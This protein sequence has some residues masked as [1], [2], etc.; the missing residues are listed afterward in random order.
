MSRVRHQNIEINKGTN[1]NNTSQIYFHAMCLSYK[2]YKGIYLWL[3]VTIAKEFSY[4]IFCSVQKLVNFIPD[5][6]ITLIAG[7]KNI[8][9]RRLLLWLVNHTR[10]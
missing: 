4:R 3:V 9:V 1:L 7:W 6:L 5:K 10:S 2:L 8:I